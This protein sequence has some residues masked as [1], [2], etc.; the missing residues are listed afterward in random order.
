MRRRELLVWLLGSAMVPPRSVLAQ[1]VRRARI[2]WLTVAPH[3]FIQG[4]LKGMRELGW[5]ESDTLD[6]DYAYADGRP[7][8]LTEL[9]AALA[10]EPIDVVVASG[11]DAV[12]AAG[13]A[14]KSIPIVAISSTVG[15]G[16]NLGRPKGNLTG[17]ALLYDE[18]AAKW[19]ELLAE[20]LPSAERIGVFFDHS[21][22]NKVQVEAIQHVTTTEG[23][24]LV[25][26]PVTGIEDIEPGV[27]RAQ[28]DGIPALI[29]VSSPI[30]TANAARIAELV[31]RAR[32]PAIFESRVFVEKGGLMSYGPDLNETFHRLAYYADRILKGSR[33]SDLPIERP[34]KFELL[35]NLK[36]AK[37]LN[38][39]IPQSILA[40]ADE[41]IE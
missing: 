12:D 21:A 7:E 22:S 6:M 28:R 15:S 41:V 36:T 33:P 8:K 4:F 37:T 32:L 35:I 39:T 2:A 25:L 20:I 40:R 38:L 11:S 34:T 16:G 27:D 18:I 5:V 17:I 31:E 10:H 14:I 9:A 1:Q 26:S 24:H 30:F 3:P 19:P 23:R 13:A 29:F